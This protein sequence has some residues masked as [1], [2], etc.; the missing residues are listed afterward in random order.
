MRPI[1]KSLLEQGDTLTDCT[2]NAICPTSWLVC[3]FVVNKSEWQQQQQEVDVDVDVEVEVQ[4]E[5][6]EEV[7]VGAPPPPAAGAGAGAGA[8]AEL[9]GCAAADDDAATS[10]SIRTSRTFTVG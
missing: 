2:R 5:E 4:E 9:V 7:E 10:A 6:E 1:S 8:A 3:L